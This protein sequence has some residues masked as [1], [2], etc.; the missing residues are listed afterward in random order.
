MSK[1]TCIYIVHKGEGGGIIIITVF[2]GTG[3]P[4]HVKGHFQ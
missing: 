4:L 2:L 3:L 1:Y